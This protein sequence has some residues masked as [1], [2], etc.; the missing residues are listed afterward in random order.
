MQVAVQ[1]HGIVDP[2]QTAPNVSIVH[3]TGEPVEF[4]VSF[5]NIKSLKI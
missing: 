5:L 1:A 2:V 3:K 4:V